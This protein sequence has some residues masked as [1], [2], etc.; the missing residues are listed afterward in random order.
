VPSPV[1]EIKSRLDIVDIIGGYLRLQK[2]G[3][4]YKALCPFHA[5][6]TASFFVSPERQTWHCFGCAKGGDMFSF[7]MEMDGI[8]F[9]DALRILAQRAGVVL[10]RQDPAVRNERSRIEEANELAAQFFEAQLEKSVSGGQANEY[11]VSRG[12]KNETKQLFRLGFAPASRDS[13]LRFLFDRGFSNDE[14]IRSGLAIKNSSSAIY[15]R[16]RGRIMFPIFDTHGRI[17]GFT[18]RI[19]GRETADGDPKYLN[20]P[21]TAIFDKGKILYGLD[22]AR[23]AIRT[24]N[25]VVLVEGQMDLIMSHQAGV[26]NAVATSGTALTANHLKTIKRYTDTL[27]I[28]F[29]ADNAGEA[30]TRRGLDLALEEGLMV[31]VAPIL[32]G[33][34]PADLVKD[35]PASW[36]DIV[37]NQ[38]KPI[39]GFFLDRACINYSPDDVEG[40]RKISASVLPLIARVGNNI[41]QGHWIQE[42]ASRL[43]IREENVWEELKRIEVKKEFNK[44]VES[45]ADNSVGTVSSRRKQLEEYLI[46]LLLRTAEDRNLPPQLSAQSA[47]TQPNIDVYFAASSSRAIA[48]ALV[49]GISSEEI[50]DISSHIRSSIAN[51]HANI[52][53]TLA[54]QASMLDLAI[55]DLEDEIERCFREIRMIELRERLDALSTELAAVERSGDAS[56]LSALEEEFKL[57]SFEL[58]QII[59]G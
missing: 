47:D 34:D 53:D 35:A 46:T 19:F 12:L 9:V 21:E 3:I 56:R 26:E 52:F 45:K 36:M 14:I 29:D 28:A 31:R 13:L 37:K 22:K 2:A 59:S 58:T 1:E 55:I 48:Q 38:T 7:L 39:I 54:M 17:L 25:A 15:D 33:K 57:V 30:A 11:L 16:F 20:T 23:T 40:K 43:G 10:T 4:N 49:Q 6:K 5:E 18:G 27:I 42:L 51:E 50:S 41:E 32:G 8:E 44:P 24:E